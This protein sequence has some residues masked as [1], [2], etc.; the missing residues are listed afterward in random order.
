MIAFGDQQ[1]DME[2][3]RVAGFGVAMGNSAPEVQACADWVAGSNESD[4]IAD[5]LQ[6]FVL[7]P[8]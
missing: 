4:A 6:R 3:L 8:K 5:A 1:N 2:M 7:T